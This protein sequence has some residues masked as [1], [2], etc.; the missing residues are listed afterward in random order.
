MFPASASAT[1]P[2]VAVAGD[3]QVGAN[4]NILNPVATS[5]LALSMNPDAAWL[6]GDEA[7]DATMAEYNTYPQHWGRLGSKLDV[8]A[9]NHDAL[10]MANYVNYFG[11]VGMPLPRATDV[12]SWRAYFLDSD[13]PL[14]VGSPTY[15]FVRDDLAAHAGRPIVAMWHHPL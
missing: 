2:V 12:G 5:N 14:G 13:A 1:D 11:S 7:D 3:V 10:N 9:G 8:V 4:L 6:A 15:N